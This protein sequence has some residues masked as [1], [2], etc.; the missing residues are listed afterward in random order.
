[1]K[2]SNVTLNEPI[3]VEELFDLSVEAVWQAIT[4]HGEMVQW[5]FDNLPGFKAEVGFKVKFPVENPPRTFTHNWEVV[6]VKESKLISY[7]WN[8]DEY[9]G[10]SLL[11]M[12]LKNLNGKAHFKLV[13]FTTESFPDDIPEFKRESGVEGWKFFVGRLKAFLSQ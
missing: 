11:E 7:T 12:H 13:H 3:V 1:M 6:K 9:P 2:S 8:Y 4:D 5:Y 10:D